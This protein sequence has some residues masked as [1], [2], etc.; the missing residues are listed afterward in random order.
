MPITYK[1]AS[2]EEVVKLLI[3]STNKF[4]ENVFFQQ[5]DGS[6]SRA[7]EYNSPLHEWVKRIYFIKIVD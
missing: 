4:K 3:A 7:C 5:Q 2:F 6:L 1:E